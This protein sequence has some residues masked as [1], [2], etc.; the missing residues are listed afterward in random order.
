MKLIFGATLWLLSVVATAETLHVYTES[1]PP[2][3]YTD[4]RGVVVGSSTDRVREILENAGY[5]VEFYLMPW[6][7]SLRMVSQQENALVYSLART[8]ERESQFFWIAPVSEFQLALVKLSKRQDIQVRSR[9]DILHYAFSAQR[10]DIGFNW[11]IANGLREGHNL[12]SCPDI[13]C[14][15]QQLSLGTVDMII[16][17][18]ALIPYSARA[19]SMSE[20]DVET[21]MFIPEL[22]VEGFLAASPKMAK[23]RVIALQQ[24]ALRVAIQTVDGAPATPQ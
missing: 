1:S 10:D 23:P 19:F 9:S 21:V 11:L 4:E 8:P 14:S 24:S 13:Q 7:R 15:W 2:Y 3:H 22:K 5:D 17:D 20:K 12:H 18:P 6:A 16:E